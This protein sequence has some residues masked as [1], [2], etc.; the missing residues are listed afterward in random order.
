MAASFETA[1][2]PIAKNT[3]QSR[4]AAIGLGV[5]LLI[6]GVLAIIFP[7]VATVTLSLVI[8]AALVVYGLVQIIDGFRRRGSGDALPEALFG[9]LGVFAGVL[10]LVSPGVGALSLTVVLAV[11]FAIDAI[12]RTGF[13]FRGRSSGRRGWLIGGAILSALLALIIL[14]G[15][16]GSAA[17]VIGLLFGAHALFAGAVLLVTGFS[18]RAR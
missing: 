16:P 3:P 18:G 7:A 2:T 1:E 17:F 11:Y 6:V 9:V 8:G 10:I 4:G 13:A 5:A 12:T 14:A 15:L